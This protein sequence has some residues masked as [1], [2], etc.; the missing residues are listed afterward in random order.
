MENRASDG[1]IVVLERVARVKPRKE[2]TNHYCLE[3]VTKSQRAVAL[4]TSK[5]NNIRHILF[6]LRNDVGE[7]VI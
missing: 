6:G 3:N 1:A 4:L 7:S 5:G 2:I